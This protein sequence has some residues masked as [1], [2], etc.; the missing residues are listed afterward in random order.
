MNKKASLKSK[1]Q[2]LVSRMLATGVVSASEAMG[3]SDEELA[4]VSAD[5]GF[6]LPYS[7]ELFLS[8][9][10]KAKTK[11]FPVGAILFDDLGTVYHLAGYFNSPIDRWL[12]PDAIPICGDITGEQL[13]FVLASDDP[14]D[15]P[16]YR[17]ATGA[18]YVEKI[19]DSFWELMETE[20][21]CA[22]E[23]EQN[24]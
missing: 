20:M 24:E 2:E 23:R 5:V 10:G 18:D 21:N 11:M 22:L 14:I 16:V 15:P 3:C 9:I 8:L 4:Q 12:P 13:C 17:S 6:P 7:Y 19:G 1:A